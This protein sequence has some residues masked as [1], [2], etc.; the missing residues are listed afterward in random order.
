MSK[1]YTGKGLRTPRKRKEEE[2][3]GGEELTELG[4]F[5]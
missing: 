5:M 1:V 2:E 3:E 4:A